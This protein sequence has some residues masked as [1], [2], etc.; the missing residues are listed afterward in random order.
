M[1]W[2]FGELNSEDELDVNY[3]SQLGLLRIR[4]SCQEDTL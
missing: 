1:V 2:H 3:I 4:L